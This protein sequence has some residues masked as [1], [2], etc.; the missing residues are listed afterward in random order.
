MR[1]IMTGARLAVGIALTAVALTVACLTQ[2]A[3]ASDPAGI[4]ES[5]PTDLLERLTRLG[6]QTVVLQS[7]V[8]NAELRVRLRRLQRE[9]TELGDQPDPRPGT[10]DVSARDRNTDRNEDDEERIPSRPTVHSIQGRGSALRA[11]LTMPRG[12]LI[13][14]RTGTEV[15][16]F[17]DAPQ[18]ARVGAISGEGV[19]LHL[20]D[21]ERLLLPLAAYGGGGDGQLL[22]AGQVR[23]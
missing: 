14:V 4:G 21:D 20:P 11:V 17:P 8:A 3:W 1:Q 16:P 5:Q 12:G 9:L 15:G 6:D 2:T 23:R 13:Q 10:T 19:V 22:R 18:G 7:E